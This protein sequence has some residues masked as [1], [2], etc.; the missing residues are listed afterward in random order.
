MERRRDARLRSAQLAI[1]GSLRNGPPV[2]TR[3]RFLQAPLGLGLAHID[4][5]AGGPAETLSH[6]SRSDHARGGLQVTRRHDV[7][8][9][10]A[11]PAG[12]AAAYYLATAGFDVLLLDKAEFPR[13]K[14]CGDG[15]T[16]R[17]LAVLAGVGVLDTLQQHGYRVA[18]LG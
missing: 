18:W 15:L 13:D 5:L 4:R 2:R 8:I 1:S 11:G 17:A 3:Q 7:V 16:P 10:G 12:S 9:V 6:G 14:T